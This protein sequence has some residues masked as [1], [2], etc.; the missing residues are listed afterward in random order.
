VSVLT[1][2]NLLKKETIIIVQ[3]VAPVVSCQGQAGYTC[4]VLNHCKSWKI[5]SVG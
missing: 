5:C 1:C 3:D 2:M 4:C